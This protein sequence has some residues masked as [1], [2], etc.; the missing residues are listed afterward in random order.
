M[1]MLIF[2]GI[3]LAAC[4]IQGFRDEW[5]SLRS[6]VGWLI[7]LPELMEDR[8]AING[9]YRRAGFSVLEERVESRD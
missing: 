6:P 2:P 5:K 4:F 3:F 1:Y 9:A 7:V 8:E